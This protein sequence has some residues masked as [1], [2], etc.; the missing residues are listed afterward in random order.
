MKTTSKILS[1]HR[2]YLIVYFIMNYNFLNFQS[3]HKIIMGTEENNKINV[4]E[5]T[6]CMEHC[7]VK[8]H[9]PTDHLEKNK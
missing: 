1:S 8:F 4:K 9:S 2:I 7:E 6:V 5:N 3:K